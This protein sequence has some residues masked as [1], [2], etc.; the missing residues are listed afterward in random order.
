VGVRLRAR[1]YP[2]IRCIIS[3]RKIRIDAIYDL[4]QVNTGAP[5]PLTRPRGLRA[6]NSSALPVFLQPGRSEARGR[7]GGSG[8]TMVSSRQR[9]FAAPGAEAPRPSQDARRHGRCISLPQ[10]RFFSRGNGRA[11]ATAGA[12]G[13]A[14]GLHQ[15]TLGGRI[16]FSVSRTVSVK[17]R[18]PSCSTPRRISVGS[19]SGASSVKGRMTARTTG[20][21]P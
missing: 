2:T 9:P 8:L 13:L 7:E 6:F 15:G 14:A 20:T 16:T 17:L 10:K 18:V 4:A 12:R 19:C 1:F 3:P 21:V 5:T 11:A